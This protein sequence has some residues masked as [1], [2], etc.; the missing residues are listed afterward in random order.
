M[1]TALK[2]LLPGE[3][4]S[5]SGVSISFETFFQMFQQLPRIKGER[6]RWAR[7]LGMEGV[8]ARLL[9]KGNVFDGLFALREL[10][11]EALESHI[12][13]VSEAF[14]A[15]FPMILR[16]GL[17]KLQA[18]A[19]ESSMKSAVQA[20]IN[21]KF[22]LEGAFVGHYATLDDFYRGPEALI[23]V[24]NPRIFEGTEKEHCLRQNAHRTF[25]TSNYAIV[26]WPALEWEFVVCPKV[27]PLP[28]LH[29]FVH[30]WTV[31]RIVS[32]ISGPLVMR[33]LPSQDG[34]E[35]PH[36]PREKSLWRDPTWVG[37]FGRSV[38][39]VDELL[40][41]PE[42]DRAVR[43]AGLLRTEVICLRLYTGPLPLPARRRSGRCVSA[44]QPRRSCGA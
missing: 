18:V 21:S 32:F 27:P 34:V 13:E 36:T 16:S 26:T 12:A 10:E 30:R 1:A 6:I 31:S 25:K 19:K 9:K 11:G 37:E 43:K 20:H 15:I 23:G 42:V 33:A 3:N 14:T 4:E 29:C 28:S 38:I 41:L 44:R 35:Y 8:L 7:S 2:N 17:L 24:P 22:V 5:K 39:P 40:R